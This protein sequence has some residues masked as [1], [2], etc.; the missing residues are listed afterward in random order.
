[1][2]SRHTR[3]LAAALVLGVTAAIALGASAHFIK[4]SAAR[5][6]NNLNVSFKIAGLGD[7]Q[8]ITV[9]ASA[10]ATANYECINNGGKNPSAAN[11]EQV[12]A[13]VSVSGNFTSDKNGNVNGTLT[14]TPP[15]S[16]LKCPS[17]QRLVLQSVSYDRVSVSGGGDTENIPGSF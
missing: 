15:P 14:I 2:R 13:N 5:Q 4:A 1:M 6:L 9:T 8:T 11:K 7:N 12:I 16:T 3:F 17:G 10:R